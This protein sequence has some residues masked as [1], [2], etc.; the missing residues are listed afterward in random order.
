MI[1]LNQF[2]KRQHS[3]AIR[4]YHIFLC[5]SFTSLGALTLLAT[6]ERTAIAQ[7][8][9]T[10]D[11]R[12]VLDGIGSIQVGTTIAEAEAIT[13]MRFLPGVSMGRTPEW[14]CTY[15][16]PENGPE[17]LSLMVINGE[18]VRVDVIGESPIETRSGAGIG[19][20]EDFILSLYPGKIEVSPHPYFSGERRNGHYLTYVPQD[21]ADRDYSLIFETMNGSVIRFRSGFRDAV[22]M[23][24]G[25]A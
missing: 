8:P 12:V 23:I 13:G 1:Q 2:L 4:I 11:S 25:C 18:I 21:A 10:N 17:D 3:R 7:T 9:L 19:D 24:E 14:Q 20:S 15:Y 16:R 5:L 22:A 6:T